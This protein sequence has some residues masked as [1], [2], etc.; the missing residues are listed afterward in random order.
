MEF[1]LGGIFAG[2]NFRGWNFHWVEFSL[3]GI[4]AGW[5][6][7]WVEFSWVEF[8][9]VE[10]SDHASAAVLHPTTSIIPSKYFSLCRP[11]ALL[12]SMNPSNT[13]FSNPSA[14]IAWPRYPSCLLLMVVISTL[15]VPASPKTSS[16][17]LLAVHGICI[18]NILLMNHFDFAKTGIETWTGV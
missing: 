10:F 14:L 18:L 3:G 11:L 12:P 17:V 2:W 15:S 6:F 8:S 13:L 1:S 9:W 16:F 7:R 4:F 5:N